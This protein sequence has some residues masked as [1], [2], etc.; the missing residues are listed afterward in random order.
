VLADFGLTDQDIARRITGWV[1]ALGS[2]V[3]E[4]EIREHLD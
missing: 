1:A 4:A 2:S 3:S